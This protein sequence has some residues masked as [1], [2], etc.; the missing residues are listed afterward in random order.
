MEILQGVGKNQEYYT[1]REAAQLLE[2]STKTIRNWIDKKQIEAVWNDVGRGRSHW[3]IQKKLVEQRLLNHPKVINPI[4]IGQ[5]SQIMPVTIDK[6][7]I[8]KIVESISNKLQDELQI[9]HQENIDLKDEIKLLRE[10][11]QAKNEQL[12]DLL[13][14][15]RP[16]W[17]IW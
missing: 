6:D 2:V 9:L 3:L 4:I 11:Q 16:W 15:K 17:K 5:E 12:M 1:I 14:E 10:E 8:E 13:K 7:A